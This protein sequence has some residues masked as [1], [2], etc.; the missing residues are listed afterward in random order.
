MFNVSDTRN[1]RRYLFVSSTIFYNSSSVKMIVKVMS[2]EPAILTS[3]RMVEII[4]ESSLVLDSF[5]W[6]M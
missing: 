3:Q 2:K 4:P 5:R 1:K 6:A